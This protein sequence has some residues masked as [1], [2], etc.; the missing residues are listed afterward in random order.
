[1]K[2]RE[3]QEIESRF[4]S[5]GDIEKKKKK[6]WRDS[7]PRQQPHSL[8]FSVDRINCYD[9][10]QHIRNTKTLVV[11]VATSCVIPGSTR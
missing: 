3:E 8:V 5:N 2:E 9:R 11:V 10:Y 7:A 1:M 6:R 4:I